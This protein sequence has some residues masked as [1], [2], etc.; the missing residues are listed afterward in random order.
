[1]ILSFL[2]VFLLPE[3]SNFMYKLI[4]VYMYIKKMPMLYYIF[5]FFLHYYGWL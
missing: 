4:L 1:M 3:S 2:K 5:N